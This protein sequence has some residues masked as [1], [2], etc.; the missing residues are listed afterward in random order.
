MKNKILIF[1]AA[2]LFSVSVN[3]QLDWGKFFAGGVDD[4]EVLLSGY[5]SPYLK[6]FGTSLTGGWYNTAKPHKTGGF[7]L[8]FTFNTAIVPPT[9]REFDIAELGL[10]NLEL[11]PGEENIAP[12]IAGKNNTGPQINYSLLNSRAF[13]MPKGLGFPATPT[14]MIQAGVGLIKDTEIMGRFM[15]TFAFG[16]GTLNMW[17]VGLKH[18]LKQW[19]PIIEKVPILHITLMGGY[20]KLNASLPVSVDQADIAMDNAEV[21][22][23]GSTSANAPADVWDG[24]SI[25]LASTSF[26]G[27]LLVSAD[28][29]IVCFYGGIGFATSKTNLKTNGYYP[30]LDGQG[31]QTWVTALKDPI[32]IEVKNQSGNKTKPRLNAGM[33][34]KMGVLTIHGDY[35]Y[36]DYSMVT[37]GIGVSFR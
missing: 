25:D 33:R 15:P 14:P 20:T 34:V 28:L 2:L 22:L 17:G 23:E 32:D 10:Q 6:G 37:A 21:R 7:D 11:A 8:T 35:T 26:T 16:D 19:I 13:D 9:D 12:T 30:M 29:P 5:M 31:G 4:A 1:A 36:T 24:Q 3:A 18:G 27:N